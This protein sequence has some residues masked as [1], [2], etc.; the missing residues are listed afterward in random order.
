MITHKE[1][2]DNSIELAKRIKWDY[3]LILTITKWWL[4][5]TYY[6]ADYLNIKV[7][8]VLNINSYIDTK[9]EKLIDK[10]KFNKDFSDKRVLL[11]DDLVDS[12]KT[13]QYIK[14]RYTF[15][16][17]KIATLYHKEWSLIYPN[18]CYLYNLPKNK[19]IE[20]EYES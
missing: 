16:D 7:I 11:I 5:P 15:K 1:I 3:D 20:F 17:L 13:I 12:W 2:K 6:V 4:I 18:F 8:E 19:W 10:T 14:E 9:K